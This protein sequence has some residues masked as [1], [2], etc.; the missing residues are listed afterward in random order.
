MNVI[1]ILLHIGRFITLAKDLEKGIADLAGGKLDKQD[2][3]RVLED[4]KGLVDLV[5]IPG[6]TPEQIAAVFTDIE[7]ALLG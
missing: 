6:V 3:V 4:L 1:T 5:P 7:K 2:A